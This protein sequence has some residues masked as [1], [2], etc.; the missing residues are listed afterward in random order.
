M[1]ARIDAH[2]Y[3]ALGLKRIKG[4]R[5]FIQL[6]PHEEEQHKDCQFR[7]TSSGHIIVSLFRHGLGSEMDTWGV[8]PLW[9]KR[10]IG[11]ILRKIAS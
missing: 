3:R 9:D 10:L 4:S 1:S 5:F 2:F 11:R 6:T 7:V 8:W